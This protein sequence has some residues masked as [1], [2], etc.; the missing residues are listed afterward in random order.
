MNKYNYFVTQ[1]HCKTMWEAENFIKQI[2]RKI[3]PDECYLCDINGFT[4]KILPL[5]IDKQAPA[6][7]RADMKNFYYNI[8]RTYMLG[9]LA[10]HCYYD[11]MS[12]YESTKEFLKTDTSLDNVEFIEIVDSIDN[13][14]GRNVEF[15]P[16]PNCASTSE[17]FS[18][19]Q[20][21]ANKNKQYSYYN[22]DG[23]DLVAIPQMSHKFNISLA[24][25]NHVDAEY[26]HRYLKSFEHAVSPDELMSE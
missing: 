26:L 19:A 10:G 25:Q 2:Q 13:S 12:E 23:I 21:Y 9:K 8:F 6:Q 15:C 5:I 17:K 20:N 3:K 1:K 7:Y 16:M 18:F 24:H 11:E 14:N 4:F 22:F